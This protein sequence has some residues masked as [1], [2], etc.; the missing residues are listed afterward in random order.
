M[1]PN[2]AEPRPTHITRRAEETNMTERA[3]TTPQISFLR[4]LVRELRGEEAVKQA[5]GWAWGAGF[6]AVSEQI[7][8]LK[9]ERVERRRVSDT[10]LLSRLSVKTWEPPAA[11]FYAYGNWIVKIT[12]SQDGRPYGE[13][14]NSETRKFEYVPGLARRIH[15]EHRITAEEAA[16]FGAEHSYCCFCSRDLSNPVS[17]EKGY[18]PICEK[19][20]L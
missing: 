9:A 1:E 19:K 5:V 7:S 13:V 15:A 14:L 10:A 16:K 17:V 6:E 2:A 4:D 18:G 3:A 12:L 20:Y 8:R 11:G